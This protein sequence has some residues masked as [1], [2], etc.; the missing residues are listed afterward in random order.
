MAGNQPPT[1]TPSQPDP[2]LQSAGASDT[3]ALQ[4]FFERQEQQ[5]LQPWRHGLAAARIMLEKYRATTAV[6]KQQQAVEQA[7]AAML[8]HDDVISLTYSLYGDDARRQ[9]YAGLVLG[10]RGLDRITIHNWMVAMA[11]GEDYISEH[12]EAISKLTTPLFPPAVEYAGL[13]QKL[14]L[15]AS[16]PD[17]VAGG[18]V[19]SLYAE[20]PR[21]PAT[22]KPA[23]KP[24][25]G[26]VPF[27]VVPDGT[28]G[29]A[30][31]LQAVSDAFVRLEAS[32]RDS[33]AE[34]SKRLQNLERR[35][36]QQ[37]VDPAQ[38]ARV[39][40]PTYGNQ[41]FGRG[42]AATPPAYRGGKGGP[43][44]APRGGGDDEQQPAPAADFH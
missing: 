4:A 13:N 19:E 20:A 2:L 37:R 30:V 9:I 14:L 43:P 6:Y 11:I 38:Q 29:Y 28:G 39:D 33:H 17:H 35:Q 8:S 32:V 7:K 44:R 21:R 42:G 12:G 31:D 36:N 27:S 15:L 3:K 18:G 40:P 1:V 26:A 24:Q 10:K 25:G 16:T 41:Q 23:K 22:A 5:R 34:T